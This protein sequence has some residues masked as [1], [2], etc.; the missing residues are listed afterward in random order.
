MPSKCSQWRI[1]F[2]SHPGRVSCAFG[3]LFLGAYVIPTSVFM[4]PL[5]RAQRGA[6]GNRDDARDEYDNTLG[7]LN[8]IQAEIVEDKQ[9][10]IDL[11]CAI[12]RYQ[13]YNNE[14]IAFQQS[15][16]DPQKTTLG[17]LGLWQIYFTPDRTE[18]DR[19]VIAKT[20]REDQWVYEKYE[21]CDEGYCAKDVR[22][23]Y[24]TRNHKVTFE[25][26]YNEITTLTN[27]YKNIIQG[28]PRLFSLNCGYYSRKLQTF[29]PETYQTY[30]SPKDIDQS[31]KHDPNDAQ[32]TIK[33]RRE[34]G[35][36]VTVSSTLDGVSVTNPMTVLRAPAQADAADDVVRN[37]YQFLAAT[38]ATFNATGIGYPVLQNRLRNSI[39][40]LIENT[41]SVNATLQQK[42]LV[43]AEKQAIFEEADSDYKEGLLKWVLPLFLIGFVG[44][45]VLY[46]ILVGLQE[47]CTRPEEDEAPEINSKDIEL[48]TITTQAP[49][50]QSPIKKDPPALYDDEGT[51]HSP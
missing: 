21:S 49:T 47:S 46:L 23:C 13:Q 30:E 32:V 45:G 34:F 26:D 44:S 29:A 19:K 1:S 38:I 33:Y 10:I 40:Q 28:T 9:R 18:D 51:Y 4:D 17:R 14:L 48:N 41:V 42:A 3:A 39:P 11:D 5:G 2:F 27:L 24:V 12:P 15:L 43:L 8:K 20:F 22:C 31:K 7:Q 16:N 36:R 6:K 37:L 25:Y 50:P 35:S